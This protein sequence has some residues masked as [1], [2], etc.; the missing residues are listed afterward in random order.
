M[1]LAD[2][3]KK[4]LSRWKL[5]DDQVVAATTDNAKN[6]V[7]ALELLSWQHFGCFAHT[8]QLD[9]VKK[10]M[11]VPQVSKA[12]TCSVFSQPFSLFQ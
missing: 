11:K 9:V 2:G 7:N 12:R 3:L 1:N 6:I 4:A 10:C 8:L 5:Q